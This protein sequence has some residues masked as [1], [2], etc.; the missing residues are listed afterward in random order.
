M[1]IAT[2]FKHPQRQQVSHNRILELNLQLE[3]WHLYIY[4]C[5]GTL[6]LFR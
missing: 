3:S 5:A 2:H 6:H 1:Q 4:M